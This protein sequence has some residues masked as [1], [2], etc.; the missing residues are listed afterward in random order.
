[1]HIARDAA[2]ALGAVHAARLIHR[3]LKPSNILMRAN[4]QPV[5]TDFGLAAAITDSGIERRLTPANVLVGT[6]D[7]LAPEA[8][9]GQAVDGRADLYALGVILY[10]MLAGFVPF[11]GRGPL[12]TLRAHCEEVVPPLPKLVPP[13]VQAIVDRAL[14]K[15]P[16]DR[17]AAAEEMAAM[18][19]AALG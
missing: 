5:V 19:T 8:I 14:Q 9:R 11:A 3:D 12:E 10:E 1:L 16:E 18:L 6:A 17:F 2:T 4:G 15:R 7:Y 13:A